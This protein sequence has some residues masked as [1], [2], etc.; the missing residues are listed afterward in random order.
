M[1]GPWKCLTS[2]LCGA[3]LV[4]SS[5]GFSA[6]AGSAVAEGI[7]LQ[8]GVVAVLGMPQGREKQKLGELSRDTELVF[9]FQSP[10]ADDVAAVRGLAEQA[11]LLGTRIFADQ[12]NLSRIHLADNLTDA[13]LVASSAEGDVS[14]DEILRV[15]RPEGLAFVGGKWW[16]KPQPE[17]TDC[18]SHPYHGPDNNPQSIDQLALA[19]YLTQFLAEPMFVPMPEVSVAAGGRVFRAFGHIAHK[20]NQNA[21]LNK[22]ICANAFNG[23]VLW[24]R[25][26]SGRFMIH[27]N[28]M[29]ATPDMLLMGDDES[30]K[31]IDAATGEVR[32]EIIVPDAPVWKWMALVDGVLYALVGGSEVPID[33]QPSKLAGLGHWPWGMWQGHEYADPKTNFGFGRTL[34]AID[35]ATKKRLWT[36]QAEDYLDGRSLCMHGKRIFAYSPGKFLACVDASSGDTVWRTSDPDLLAAIGQEGRAQHPVTGYATTTYAKCNEKYIFFAGPQRSQLVVVRTDDGSLAWHREP[37][38]YQLVLQEDAFFA[39]GPGNTGGK[40]AYTGEVLADLPQRRACTRATGSLDSIFYRTPGGTV[41]VE[42]ATG[43]ARHIAPMRPPCQDGV[44]ISDGHLFW[45]PWMC[46]CQLSLYGHICLAPA[47]DFNFHPAADDSRIDLAP[48]AQ[49]VKPLEIAN[50]DWTEYCGDNAR[51]STTNAAIPKRVEQRWTYRLPSEAFPTAPVTAGGLVFF[52]DRRGAVYAI[53]AADGSLRWTFYTSGPVYFPPAV[54]DGRLFVG[55]ADGRV[56]ALEAVSGRRLWTFQAAP[57]E[58]WI[59]IYGKLIST[60]P[61]SGGVVVQD[62]AVYAAAGIAHYDGT[63]VYALDAATGKVRWSNDT[64][65]STSEVVES[66]ASLQGELSI[67]D[68]QLR[69]LGG[70]VH[71]VALFDLATG[72]CLNRPNDQPVSTFH[73][74]FYAYFPEYGKYVSIDH[75]WDNGRTLRY[76]ASYEGSRHSNLALLEA[77]PSGTVERPMPL[78]RWMPR[79]PAGP[80]RKPVW[81]QGGMWVNGFIIGPEAVLLAGHAAANAA[82]P[83]T[84]DAVSDSRQSVLALISLENGRPI[85]RQQ[86][87]G[88]VV[89]DGVAIEGDRRILV[90]MEIGLVVCFGAAE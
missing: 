1:A 18:W 3:I 16:T 35:L 46:G 27:R 9:Y 47:G 54:A 2:L 86:L 26:L 22:L 69:F 58:R 84:V 25:D 51:S 88:P 15:L 89:K 7:G 32:D 53:D 80:K 17:G 66:G 67:R 59:P 85:W 13:V 73:T 38:N 11:G 20:A 28:T 87:P 62:G 8:R 83:I 61:V 31:L 76:D 55:S 65:G 74:A 60:W 57:A 34:V 39:V 33:E 52:G 68:N 77:L 78:S 75:T 4:G 6:A 19:P 42:T 44:I 81:Q 37:G 30:C 64:A 63:Y 12:G 72:K 50:D 70:G 5:G 43:A 45:G 14:R 21:M 10:E 40:V 41:R 49:E 36:R 24:Q 23:T 71:E 90:S 82:G 56:Y 29:I 79:L 48:N